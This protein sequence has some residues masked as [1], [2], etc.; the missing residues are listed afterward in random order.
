MFLDCTKRS[1][2][3][4]ATCC[5]VPALRSATFPLGPQCFSSVIASFWPPFRLSVVPAADAEK[6]PQRI[7]KGH[8]PGRA[9]LCTMHVHPTFRYVP[10]E[11]LFGRNFPWS[12]G[13]SRIGSDVLLRSATFLSTNFSRGGPCISRGLRPPILNLVML[14]SGRVFLEDYGLQHL[15]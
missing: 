7:R 10:V 14:G 2:F 12:K 1:A 8:R 3:G 11:K 13:R 4:S 5:Y 6:V 15:I 9:S